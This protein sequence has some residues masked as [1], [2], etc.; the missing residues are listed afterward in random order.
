M[1]TVDADL[2]HANTEVHM[3]EQVSVFGMWAA[4]YAK[5]DTMLNFP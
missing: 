3:C 4:H 5:A 2:W 1:Y